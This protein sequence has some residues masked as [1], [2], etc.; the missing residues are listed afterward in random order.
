MKKSL[1]KTLH[2]FFKIFI[3]F[4]I[5]TAVINLLL[6]GGLYMSHRS[7][8]KKE[9]VY[10]TQP[11]VMVEVNGHRIHVMVEGDAEADTT[12]VF[13]HSCSVVDD[14]IALQPLFD[15]LKEYRLVYVD[16]SGVGFSEI[17]G[18]PRDID[19]V[20]DETR[21]AIEKAG[22]KGKFTLVATGTG[23]IEALHWANL[24][25]DEVEGIIGISMNYPEQFAEITQDEY[26][27]FFDYLLV[28]FCKIGGQRIVKTIY[29]DNAYMLYTEMQMNIRNALVSRG[30]Y[31]TDMYNE[32]LATVDNA[33]KVAA[34]GIPSDIRM[35]MIYA[36]PLMEPYV[37]ADESVGETYSQAQ[38]DNGEVDYVSLYNQ[39][40]REYFGAY[41]N[42]MFEEMSG[43]ARLYT[44]SPEELSKKIVK[45]IDTK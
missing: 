5:G 3:I 7:K 43:P 32:D 1:K 21:T 20:L 31:T 45:F 40:A 26:C 34:E 29:P 13:L 10:L 25:P 44:Y 39:E 33:A 27:G 9:Q 23:G 28:Q 2:T 19:T 12:L 11:G 18:A 17:S 16:R 38:Q 22:V 41:S 24:Y 36:N 35:Y 4:M 8:L 15:R 42:I 6:V 37:S 14:A 30:G